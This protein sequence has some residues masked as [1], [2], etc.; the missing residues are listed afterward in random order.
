MYANTNSKGKNDEIK[1]KRFI[2]SSVSIADIEE[3]GLLMQS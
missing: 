2:F 1:T 3:L